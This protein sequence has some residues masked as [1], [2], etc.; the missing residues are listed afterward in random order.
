MDDN[1]KRW[2]VLRDKFV[3]ELKKVK[4][5]K[6]GDTSCWAHFF[7]AYYFCK[8]L[9]ATDS[10]FDSACNDPT[11]RIIWHTYA[12]QSNFSLDPQLT[13]IPEDFETEPRLIN[14]GSH[15]CDQYMSMQ[16]IVAG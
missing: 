2:K 8:T 12:T 11:F 15:R 5:E 3:R 4:S 7:K 10:E 13:D 14:E 6:S 16:P 1:I 9:Y